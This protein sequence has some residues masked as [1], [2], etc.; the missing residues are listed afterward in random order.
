MSFL[1]IPAAPDTFVQ[2]PGPVTAVD[3][4]IGASYQTL[5]A[6]FPGVALASNAQGTLVGY[7]SLT[8]PA[9]QIIW[10][11]AASAWQPGPAVP[12]CIGTL[13]GTT[14]VA[15]VQP[16]TYDLRPAPEPSAMGLVLIGMVACFVANLIVGG[17]RR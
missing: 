1:S 6:E 5:A 9:Q 16:P 17:K 13:E 3:P 11:P 10:A 8:D 4:V 7:G 15:L 2:L 14:C 12:N